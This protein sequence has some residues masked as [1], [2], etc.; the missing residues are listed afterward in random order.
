VKI[1]VLRNFRFKLALEVVLQADFI[2]RINFGI[3]VTLG[4]LL[5]VE[6]VKTTSASSS[7]YTRLTKVAN[8]PSPLDSTQ[9]ELSNET[10]IK[11]NQ[12]ITGEL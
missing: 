3:R 1:K 9:K 4:G 5:V 8:G 12:V 6:V 7:I 2:S 10:L 11:I